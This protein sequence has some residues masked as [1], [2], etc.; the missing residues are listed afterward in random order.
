M[1]QDAP[2]RALYKVFLD[3]RDAAAKVL[4]NTT[5]ADVAGLTVLPDLEK[6]ARKVRVGEGS[7]PPRNGRP[8]NGQRRSRVLT[9]T[10]R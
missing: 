2:H 4:D 10:G 9:L 3:V 7:A 8:E 5:V 6:P 1:E